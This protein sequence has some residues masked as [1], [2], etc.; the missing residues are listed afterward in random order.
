MDQGRQEHRQMDEALLPHV[1][2]QSDAVATVRVGLQSGQL[3]AATGLASR[4]KAL[5][6]ERCGR[7]RSVQGNAALCQTRQTKSLNSPAPL[8]TIPRARI[9]P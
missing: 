4:C 6:A 8:L 3:S 9:K 5:V 7:T 1:Q 2:G